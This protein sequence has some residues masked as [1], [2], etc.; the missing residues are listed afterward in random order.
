MKLVDITNREGLAK[1]SIVEID[2]KEIGLPIVQFTVTDRISPT[3]E[4]KAL[5]VSACK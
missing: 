4:A 5:L 3:S 1:A 2:G